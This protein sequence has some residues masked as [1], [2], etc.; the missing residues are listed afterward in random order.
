MMR[1]VFGTINMLRECVVMSLGNI[2]HNRMRSFLTIL[3][4]MIGVSA[5]IA[6]ITT[7][8]ACPTR[9]PARFRAWAQAP[10]P[11]T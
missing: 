2:A 8:S 9:C 4:I 11:S 10:S 6:L 1:K 3:G 7:I 5:V